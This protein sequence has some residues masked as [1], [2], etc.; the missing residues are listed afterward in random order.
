[1]SVLSTLIVRTSGHGCELGD[2][3]GDF[4][5]STSRPERILRQTMKQIEY[6]LPLLK[7]NWSPQ[8]LSRS[9]RRKDTA[10]RC[11]FSSTCKN[12]FGIAITVSAH[13]KLLHSRFSHSRLRASRRPGRTGATKPAVRQNTIKSTACS[14]R[15][16]I[17][18]ISLRLTVA[19]RCCEVV[20][21]ECRALLFLISSTG[22]G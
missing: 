12:Q 7:L 11:S 13:G 18:N 17:A 22:L 5:L 6:H 14:L 4:C 9:P 3:R 8:P 19:R 16:M 15:R 10:P 21:Q 2:L 20:E 1:M